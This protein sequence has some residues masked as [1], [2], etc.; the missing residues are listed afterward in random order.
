MKIEMLDSELKKIIISAIKHE[1]DYWWG[2][3]ESFTPKEELLLKLKEYR[4]EHKGYGYSEIFKSL[5][6]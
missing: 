2:F 4:K 6:E 5:E 1:R 3:M